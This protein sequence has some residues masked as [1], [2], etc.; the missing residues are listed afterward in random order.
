[1]LIAK[2]PKTRHL[3]VLKLLKKQQK[4]VK[5]NWLKIPERVGRSLFAVVELLQPCNR[6]KLPDID[7]VLQQQLD[8]VHP[9]VDERVHHGL[10]QR[11]RA[12][13]HPVLEDL[14]ACNVHPIP[15]ERQA[16]LFG[17]RQMLRLEQRR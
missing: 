13:L 2:Q 5:K 4:L 8:K 1:M 6:Q 12:P 3:I 14:R 16:Q 17:R 11:A 10:L 7:P 9:I 15:G